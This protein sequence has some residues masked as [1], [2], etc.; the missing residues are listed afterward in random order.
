MKR[1]LSNWVLMGT[2]VAITATSVVA[3]DAVQKQDAAQKEVRSNLE[4]LIGSLIVADHQ[5]S[6]MTNVTLATTAETL[7][8]GGQRK[9]EGQG[10][11]YYFDGDID[12]VRVWNRPLTAAELTALAD[13]R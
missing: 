3:Q 6:T 11:V 13:D 2:L 10:F 1:W 12:D 7:A 5:Q 4:G 8:I 9:T